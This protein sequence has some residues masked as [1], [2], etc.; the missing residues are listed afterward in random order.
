MSGHT[1][2][3]F[4]ENKS[5]NPH[6]E[7]QD[8][9]INNVLERVVKINKKLRT[10]NKNY[11]NNYLDNYKSK[12]PKPLTVPGRLPNKT[13]PVYEKK[14]ETIAEDGFIKNYKREPIS[15]KERNNDVLLNVTQRNSKPILDTDIYTGIDRSIKPDVGIGVV[16]NKIV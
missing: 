7:V 5:D 4:K 6:N 3:G 2:F 13:A 15:H 12:T 9:L 8:N 11:P 1:N 14:I 16:Q 10:D